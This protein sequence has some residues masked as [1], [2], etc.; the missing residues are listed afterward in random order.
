MSILCVLD[1]VTYIR[2][3]INILDSITWEI[4]PG[5]V[6]AVVGGNGSG[7]TTLVEIIAGKMKPRRGSV[8]YSDDILKGHIGYLS[9][10]EQEAV[11]ARERKLDET[12][13]G[14]GAIDYG[15]TGAELIGIPEKGGVKS[16]GP[17][18]R[19][20]VELLRISHLLSS[21]CRQFSTGEFRKVLLC[22]ELLYRPPLLLLDE[23]F[24]GLDRESREHIYDVF[25]EMEHQGMTVVFF[26]HREHEVPAYV[27]ESNP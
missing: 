18:T 22:R 11:L 19:R 16:A 2:E 25:E 4:E 26:L 10:E 17:D 27:D 9:F 20:L 8:M 7:K 3:Y 23:P 13:L 1:N 6:Y 14:H 24:D 15:S 5:K 21:G 12:W